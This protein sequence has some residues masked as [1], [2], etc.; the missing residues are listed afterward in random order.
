M[1]RL[2]RSPYWVWT[3]MDPTSKLLVVV[4]VGSRTPAMVAGVTDH[5]WSLKEVLLF[6]VLP[7]PQAQTV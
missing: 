1:K 5:V 7:W 3:A 4:D 6:R 2:E